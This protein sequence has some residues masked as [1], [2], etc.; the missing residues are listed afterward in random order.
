MRWVSFSVLL[1]V[2]MTLVGA[3]VATTYQKQVLQPLNLEEDDIIVVR[4]G[5]GF[6]QIIQELA[7]RMK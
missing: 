6:R 4:S 2:A 1:L 3:H 5:Q 7:A